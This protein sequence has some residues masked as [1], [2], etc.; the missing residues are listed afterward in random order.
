MARF[1]LIRIFAILF[2]LPLLSSAQPVYAHSAQASVCELASFGAEHDG[3]VYETSALYATDFRHGAWLVDPENGSCGIQ[4]GVRQND[5]DGSMARFMK[6][7]VEDVMRYGPGTMRALRA[8]LV[9]HWVSGASPGSAGFPKG[10]VE[11]RRVFGSAPAALAPNH[12]S[13]R[14]RV[15]HAVQLRRQG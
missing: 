3:R 2:P 8:Q 14:T 15:P 12:S 9:F 4:L 7:L 5:V 6:E 11:L 13:G 1:G 10:E